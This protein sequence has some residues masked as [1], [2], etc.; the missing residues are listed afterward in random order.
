M[1]EFVEKVYTVSEGDGEAE[2]CLRVDRQITFPL[3]VRLLA[4]PD[5]AE[6]TYVNRTLKDLTVNRSVCY[7]E[8]A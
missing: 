6:G 8:I 5:T 3:V 4:S 7:S 1:V 2:V